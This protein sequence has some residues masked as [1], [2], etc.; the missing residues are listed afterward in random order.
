MATGAERMPPLEA[1]AA[2]LRRAG[3]RPLVIPIGGSTPLGARACVDTVRELAAQGV[4]L[5]F[6]PAALVHA[7]SSGGTQA[8]LVVGCRAAGLPAHVIGVS[9][10]E[11]RADLERMVRAVAEPLA[12]ALGVGPLPPEVV[13]VLD[14]QVGD[15]YG[16]PTP[17]SRE[18]AR[19]SRDWRGSC[20]TPPTGPRPPPA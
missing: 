5:G 2:E 19:L 3:R 8:G 16:R 12:A 11:P 13:E 17:A 1:V 18:A 6:R 4:A 15:G 9:P 7:S 10:D 20:W 14:D